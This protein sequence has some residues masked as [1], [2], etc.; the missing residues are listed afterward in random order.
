MISARKEC[1]DLVN[2]NKDMDKNIKLKIKDIQSN[3]DY[4][5]E[6]EGLEY[7]EII[8]QI[9]I[10]VKDQLEIESLAFFIAAGRSLLC[11]KM[12]EGK[13]KKAEREQKLDNLRK[14][15]FAWIERR[16]KQEDS[17]ID[18][19][20]K[21][22]IEADKYQKDG[23][24]YCKEIAILDENNPKMEKIYLQKKNKLDEVKKYCA[25]RLQKIREEQEKARSI[26]NQGYHNLAMVEDKIAQ[27]K[28][29]LDEKVKIKEDVELLKETCAERSHQIQ[30]LDDEITEAQSQI[31]IV[32][33]K[34]K[35]LLKKIDELQQYSMSQLF[36]TCLYST[37]T[38]TII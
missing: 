34:K 15:A 13:E 19:L 32:G 29:T 18:K 7:K 3:L 30:N 37:L 31:N 6:F 33:E 14:I 21:L 20:R 9:D 27:I 22:E 17:Y 8:E 24:D 28:P 26:L 4:L 1:D 36:N 25:N 16:R 2:L 38:S 5:K 23:D 35:D 12:Q 11:K 10:L